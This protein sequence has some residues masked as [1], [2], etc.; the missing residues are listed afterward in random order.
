MPRSIQ[1]TQPP[2]KF[3]PQR[4]NPL[5]LQIVRWLLPIALRFR[6]RPWL[7]A[8]IVKVEAKNVE[9]LAELY[10][11][12]QSGK[13]RF[14]LAFRH[15]EVEDP[16]CMLYLLSRIVPQIARQEGITLQSLVHSYFLYDR[17][18][19][20]WAGK[21]LGWLFSRIGGVPVRRGKRIDRQAIQTARDLFANGELP[22]AVAPEGGTNGHSGI[23]SPLEPG[24]AQLGFW[25]VEDLQKANRTETVIIVPIAIQYRYVEPPWSKLDWLLTKLEA[26]SGLEVKEIDLGDAWVGLRR[27]EI[28]YQRLCHLVEYLI[29]EMEEFYRRFYHQ[30]IPKTISIHE[31]ASHN[32]VLIARLHRLLDKSLQVSEQYFGVQAQGS[33]IDRCRR[34]EEAGWNYIYREDLPDIN[35]L[36]P[37][38][39]G[40]ADWIAQE[41]DL[42]MRHMRIVESFVAVTATYI[43]EQPTAERFAETALLIFDMLSR[44]QDTTLPGRPR[45]GLRQT[46]IT[47]GEPIS[48]T[49][50]S[51]N[52]QGDRLAARE[53]VSDLTRDLQLALEKMIG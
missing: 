9:V 15:P 3:I 1:S 41:A 36:P 21:W 29:T 34:L 6:T 46:Q 35:G 53:A 32:Q 26:D 49:E 23:V 44:I 13:I 16:L 10:Q 39:R 31:S 50:R 11:Q 19:T 20:V 37:F 52:C 30:D 51:Q 42:R 8:G 5:V 40:L 18:M 38:K 14:L 47:V 25:C 2:L 22:I 4:L 45:L 48:V 12:F 43:Q 24:V 17:G 7:Q 33:F 28:Y 27:E